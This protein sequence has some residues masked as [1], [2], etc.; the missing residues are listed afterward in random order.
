MEWI[1]PIN[2]ST[3]TR[4]LCVW[5]QMK[6]RDISSIACIQCY[7]FNYIWII[8]NL[9]WVT[10][11]FCDSRIKYEWDIRWY[12]EIICVWQVYLESFIKIYSLPVCDNWF[13]TTTIENRLTIDW[14][15]AKK[16]ELNAFCFIFKCLFHFHHGSWYNMFVNT[17]CLFILLYISFISRNHK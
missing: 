12:C 3:Q 8:L 10:F 13:E 16:F 11:Y 15:L 6:K 4:L 7:F 9:I 17:N 2:C 14:K 1:R 5:L